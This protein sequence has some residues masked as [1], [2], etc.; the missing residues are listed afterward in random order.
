MGELKI[1]VEF[2][3]WDSYGELMAFGRQALETYPYDSVWMCDEFQYEDA[4]TVLGSMAMELDASVGTMVTFPWRNPLELA[5]RFA[6]ISK[7]TRP[8]RQVAIGMGGGGS[9]QTQVIGEKGNPLAVMRESVQLLRGLLA[10]RSVELAGFP[11]LAARFRYNTATS[12]KLYFPPV[13]EPVPVYLAAGGPKML[14]LAGAEADGVIITQLQVRH[15]PLGAGLGL[16]AE[17]MEIVEAARQQSSDPDRPFK[18]LYNFHLSVARNGHD[19]VQWAKRNASY[20]LTGAYLRYPHFL[21]DVGI[22]REAVGHVAEA[23]QKGLGLEEAARRVTDDMV[24]GTGLVIAGTPDEVAEAL[25][26][27]LEHVE[28]A[29]FDHAVMGVPLGPDVSEALELLGKE[30]LPAVLG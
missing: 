21:D 16:F 13:S 18:R 17:D 7:Q 25:R 15:C 6:T 8:G 29:G 12:A 24:T 9:V 3:P 10:G 28:A 1:G 4:I 5:Q 14:A 22:D 2:W 23:Y 19:A 30:V 27:Q 26:S 20:G 11:E